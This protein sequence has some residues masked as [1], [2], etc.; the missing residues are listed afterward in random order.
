MGNRRDFLQSTLLAAGAATGAAAGSAAVAATPA[1]APGTA[2]GAATGTHHGPITRRW[3][4]QRWLLDNVIRANGIDWDQPRSVLY[5][6]PCGPEANADFAA[7][8]ARVQKYADIA[9]AFEAA[10][11]RREAIA[12]DAESAGNPVW[13]RENFFIAAILWAASQW[14]FET[15]SEHNLANNTRKR[16]CYLAYARLADHRV[17]AAYVTLPNG[18]RLP[19]WFHLPPG[20]TGGR[21]PAVVSIPGMDGFKEGAVAMYGDRWLSRGIAV[22]VV[23]GPGQYEAAVNN[24]HVSV[25]AWQATGRATMEWMLARPEIDPA[26]IGIVGS[27]F[28]S[29]FSTIACSAEPRFKAIAVANTC[30]E[31]GCHTIFEEASPTFKMRFMYMSG[32]TDEAQFDRFRRDITWEGH[33]DNL[34]C[35]YLCIGGEADELSPLEHTERMMKTLRG[36]KQLLIYADARHAVGGVPSAN[37]GPSPSAYAADWMSARLSGKPFAS[38]RWFIEPSGRVV[39]T[40]Y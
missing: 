38:E 37:L 11:R 36:P 20:Y 5:N 22:L 21:I 29:M 30:L 7:I 15:N 4:E 35:P 17:E 3:I 9:P 16:E 2:A 28:G 19:G 34:R 24:I 32:M 13:A 40:A 39:K 18:Q 1:G 33:V 12:R 25:P 23:E 6:G 26:R 10:A 8:R 27:S 14:T 31:P